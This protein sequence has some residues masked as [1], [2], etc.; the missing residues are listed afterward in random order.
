VSGQA[1][2]FFMA[3]WVLLGISVRPLHRSW[4]VLNPILF[5]DTEFYHSSVK[6]NLWKLTFSCY[7]CFLLFSSSDSVIS[8]VNFTMVTDTHLSEST[9]WWWCFQLHYQWIQ[10]MYIIKS[11]VLDIHCSHTKRHLKWIAYHLQNK[12]NISYKEPEKNI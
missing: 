9:F 12:V 2:V 5:T 7:T 4:S 1:L 11:W 10:L 8:S 3:F 6:N